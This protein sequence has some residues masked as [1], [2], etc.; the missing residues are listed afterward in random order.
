[1]PAPSR[2]SGLVVAIGGFDGVHL[3]HQEILRRTRAIAR[4]RAGVPAV[5]TF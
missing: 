3:G 4:A 2:A 5:L 1:M